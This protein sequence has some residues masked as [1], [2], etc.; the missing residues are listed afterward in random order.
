MLL[1]GADKV[2]DTV[3]KFLT[4]SNNPA[5]FAGAGVG[6]HAGLATWSQF[7][8][9]LATVASNYD[10][11]TGELIR[12][13]SE[14]GHYLSAAAVYKSCPQIPR[15]ELYSQVAVPFC[16]PTSS[17]RLR[18]LASLP[19]TAV[20][21]TNYDRSL[22]DAFAGVLGRSPKTVELGDPTMRRAL[23]FTDFY[24]ARIHGRAEV[25]ET[26]V[27]A[28]DDYQRI[29][30]DECYIDFVRHILTRY[31]C[32][33]VGFSF[34]D[35]AI[36]SVFQIIEDR[37]SPGFPELHLALVSAATDT[38]LMARL[39]QFN[40]ET[41]QYEASSE[42]FALWEGITLASRKFTMA[43]KVIK[44]AASPPLGAIKR[45]I[46]TSYARAKLENEL[47]PLRDI[48]I[49]GIIVDILTE[50]GEKGLTH[51]QVSDR[52]RKY[53]SLPHSESRQLAQRR[54]EVLSGLGWCHV[55]DGI[56]RI[57]RETA[58]VLKEDLDILI[59]GVISRAEVRE[60]QLVTAPLRKVAAQSIE[61][62]L[63]ARGWDLGAH[64][65][66]ALT[67]DVPSVLHTASSAVAR[68]GADLSERQREALG[69]ACYDL[70]QN[71]DETES[72]VLAELGRVAFGLQLVI[73]N[74]CATIAHQAVL[75][76]RIYL[77]ASF[78][79]PAIVEGHPYFSVYIDTLRRFDEAGRAANMSVRVA[80]AEDFLNEIIAHR[81]R[82]R[83]EVDAMSLGNPDTLADHILYHGADNVNVFIGAYSNWVKG[84]EGNG[85][86]DEFVS[87]VA[88]YRTEKELARFLSKRG[89][90]TVSL[91]FKSSDEVDLYNE[92]R[93]GLTNAYE[94]DPRSQYSPKEK[95]LINH[96]AGQLTQLSLDLDH[97]LRS[98]FVTADMRLRRLATGPILGRPGDTIISHRGLVQLVDILVGIRS[99]PVVTSRLFWGGTVTDDAVLIRNYLTSRALQC[100]DEAMTMTLADVLR[101][102]VPRSVENAK[103]EQISLFPGDGTAS[104]IRRQRFLDHLADQFYA[105]MSEAI[106]RRFPD[107]YNLAEKIR[108]EQLE[109]HIRNTLDLINKYETELR[110][111]DDPKEQ[112]RCE[113]ELTELR[114]HLRNYRDELEEMER[115]ESE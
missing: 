47:Q 38:R 74:P 64:F 12:R 45:F 71:P 99:D 104:K 23:Y 112:A 59:D 28:E 44:P 24:I 31:S 86:F 66:G 63:L 26:I 62:I 88:P 111:S 25:P 101:S 108:R 61:D 92:I 49:D 13:R 65:A 97:G 2:S 56:I 7:M 114:A 72:G 30:E 16:S 89:I 55:H 60:G 67:G 58:N 91:Y 70:F 32:L 93:R 21:T 15:G 43:Q 87:Q 18:P 33:F 73:N 27:F 37:L 54:I 69:R 85:T 79:M 57:T 41:V 50:A 113:R 107:E 1:M 52:L 84:L 105:E 68:C 10:P 76:E 78:L 53:L 110:E 48:V 83:W 51:Q 80:V 82:A 4:T 35:P 6:A 22:L 96:E 46:A 95:V 106:R 17:E 20:F 115:K 100:Q 14:S 11:L 109:R 98:L 81:D 39:A 34:A 102:L 36:D 8:E 77:D 75:P 5:L 103:Q 90:G 29:R 19:F 9:H 40:I 3:C 94:D 42:H